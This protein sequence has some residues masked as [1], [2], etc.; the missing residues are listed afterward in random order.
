MFPVVSNL[1]RSAM[2][3][4]YTNTPDVAFEGRH[5]CLDISSK[6]WKKSSKAVM[7]KL[8]VP[9]AT[10]EERALRLCLFENEL[11]EEAKADKFQ[12]TLLLSQETESEGLRVIKIGVIKG[13]L[14]SKK[15]GLF[16]LKK[17]ANNQPSLRKPLPPGVVLD[18]R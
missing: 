12:Y 6:E 8:E 4:V 17:Q 13:I 10:P 11:Y 15:G 2:K 18:E 9:G 1:R 7:S 14:V 3:I 5:F 16:P